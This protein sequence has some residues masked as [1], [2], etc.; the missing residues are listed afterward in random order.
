MPARASAGFRRFR[1]VTFGAGAIVRGV[2][3]ITFGAGAI[4]R[5][6]RA[7]AFGVALLAVACTPARPGIELPDGAG[8]PLSDYAALWERVS[9]P[10]RGVRTMEFLLVLGGRT[11]DTTLRRTRMRAAAD[12]SGSLRIEALA[13]F[14][15]PVFVFVARG[16]AGTL[17]LPRERQV[18]RDARAADVLHALAGLALGPGDV[19]ALLTGCLEPDPVATAARRHREGTVAVE[20]QDGA[21]AY[22]RDAGD[23]QVVVAGRRGN[24]TV[25]Y[26]DHVRRLPRRFRIQVEGPRGGTDLTAGLSQVNLNTELHPAV[27]AVDVPAQYTPVTLAGLRGASPLEQPAPPAAEAAARP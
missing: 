9:G 3:T 21:T 7:L 26:T 27:F 1:T 14:G 8:V 11:G 2:R 17:L 23:G 18:V 22:L 20:L 25:E 13:P 5:G 24:L 6:F 10:C 15:A 16:D 12:R 19:H 4:V